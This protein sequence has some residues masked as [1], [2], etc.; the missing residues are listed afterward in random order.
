MCANIPYIMSIHNR[1]DK[2]ALWSDAT[3]SDRFFFSTEDFYLFALFNCED[4]YF[5]ICFSNFCSSVAYVF[6]NYR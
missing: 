6:Y 1:G 2:H 5:E 3:Y 4:I